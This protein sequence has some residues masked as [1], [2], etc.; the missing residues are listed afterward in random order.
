MPISALA[1]S[2]DGTQLALAASHT[3]EGGVSGDPMVNN[4]YV[5]SV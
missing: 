3:F 5:R 4:I 1:Y 2:R